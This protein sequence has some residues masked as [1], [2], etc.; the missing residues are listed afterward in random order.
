MGTK[1]GWEFA[2]NLSQSFLAADRGKTGWGNKWRGYILYY[3]ILYYIIL[4]I[5]YY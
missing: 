1:H 4:Y 5:I 2:P 3:I